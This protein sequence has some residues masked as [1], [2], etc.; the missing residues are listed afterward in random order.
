MSGV[1]IGV[2]IGGSL[3]KIAAVDRQGH[4]YARDGFASTDQQFVANLIEHI[5]TFSS[6]LPTNLTVEGYGFGVPCYALG[7]DWVLRNVTN[8]P[9]LEGYPLRPALAQTFGEKIAC[10][11]DTNAAGLAEFLWGAGVNCERF[12]FMGIGTGISA[13]F[14][15]RSM[16]AI[17]FTYGTLGDTGHI[18][19]EPNSP[20][21]CA[22]G[23]YGC[24][25]SLAAAPAIRRRALQVA[26]D[27]AS[28]SLL[29]V[30]LKQAG[31][32]SAPDV[33]EAAESGDA[34][35]IA[36]LEQTGR[37]I[38]IALTSYLHIFLPQ[39]IVLGGGVS[40]AGELL[41]NPVR[42]T[43]DSLASPWFKEQ[44]TGIVSSRFGTEAGAM[45]CAGLI[46][47]PELIN[48]VH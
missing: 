42:R 17:S 19:V 45:G 46:Y 1:S 43:I 14:F 35:A 10:T 25:E 6:H 4:V 11:Y 26:N 15:I 38:G 32:L 12:L 23:G 8:L 20:L 27:T 9:H 3:I 48:P 22:C 30:K 36:I 37:Y 21:K 18:I 44:L 16:G 31:D 13:S 41:L 5:R 28:E 34:A 24:L 7:E 47:Y 40:Q 29:S 33:S 2:D 39:L